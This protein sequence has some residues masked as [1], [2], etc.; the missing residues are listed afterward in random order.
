M[1]VTPTTPPAAVTPPAAENPPAAP[2]APATTTPPSDT[3]KSEESKAAVLAD[4]AKERDARQALETQVAS[5]KAAQEAQARSLAEAFGLAETPQSEDL[6]ETV[7]SLQEQ[8]AA[9]QMEANLLRVA[10]KN[11]IPAEYHDLLTETD[12]ERLQ[13]Q[14]TKVAALVK[15]AGTPAFQE[16]PGQGQQPGENSFDAQIAEATKAGN[17]Q[18]AISLKQQ[19]AALRSKKS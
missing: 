11:E 12:S 17:H 1:S 8:F 2:A 15:A 4:L 14:A 6:A 5:L 16:I 3:F 18:L 19:R 7:K 9:S 13:A 10:A